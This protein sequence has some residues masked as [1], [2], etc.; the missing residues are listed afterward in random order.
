MRQIDR[1]YYEYEFSAVAQALYGLVWNDYCDWYV[2]VSKAKLQD[3]GTRDNCLAIQDFVLRQ[4]LL[5]LHPLMPFITEELW[6]QLGF[7]GPKGGLISDSRV[8]DAS[9]SASALRMLGVRPDAVQAASVE[10]M[11][12]F[13]SQA[14]SLK[15]EH[16]AAS[17]R[18][19]RLVVKAGDAAWAT[20]EA[21]LAKLLRMAGAAGITRGDDFKGMPAAVTPLGTLGIDLAHSGGGGADRKRLSGELEA[22]GRHIAATEARLAN[23]AFVSKAPPAVLEGARRQLAEQQAKRAELERLLGPHGG[24]EGR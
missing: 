10:R 3:A 23:E 5:L 6:S 21:N 16:G 17:R 20:I 2:E 8:V 14:R 15:A 24:G 4:A 1:L 22:L 13:V 18:D 7:S 11:K 9:Q 19:V 12:A